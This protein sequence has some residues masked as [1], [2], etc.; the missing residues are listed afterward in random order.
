[1]LQY[2]QYGSS[3]LLLLLLLSLSACSMLETPQ[4]RNLPVHKASIPQAWTANGRISVIRGEE[5]WYARFSWIQQGN[6]FQIRFTGPLGETRLQVSQ[7][8]SD[9]RLNTPSASRSGDDLEQLILQ[10]TGWIFPVSSLRYWLHGQA[11]PS[12]T[13]KIQYNKTAQIRAIDQQGWHIQYTRWMPVT[14]SA[15]AESATA[16]SATAKSAIATKV[17]PKKLVITRDDLKIKIIISQWLLAQ[18]SLQLSN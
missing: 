9:V 10:E 13:A 6:D 12:V 3:V 1:M 17:L 15:T 2:R 16:K 4:T 7:T 18:H 11:E 14:E 5:N 8:S